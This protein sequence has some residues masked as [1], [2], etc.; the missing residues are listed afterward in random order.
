MY[1]WFILR[2]FFFLSFNPWFNFN[3]FSKKY[4]F[5]TSIYSNF[6][7]ELLIFVIFYLLIVLFIIVKITE[8]FK[9]ALILL[10]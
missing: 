7:V 6:N 1:L 9:G 10:Q 3:L 4:E 8:S 5:L 2:G